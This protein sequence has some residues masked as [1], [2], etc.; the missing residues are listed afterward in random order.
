MSDGR[1]VIDAIFD[2][3]PTQ[4]SA[5]TLQRTLDGLNTNRYNERLRLMSAEMKAAY[6][7][8]RQALIPF[9]RELME[10][11]FKFFKMAQGMK[12]YSG[13]NAQFINDVRRLGQEHKTATENIMKNN[14]MMKA[15]FIQGVGQ[16]LARSGQSEKIAANFQRMGNPLYSVNNGLLRVTSS[17]ERVARQGNASV[18]ALK[19]LGPTA[20]M[21]QLND[22]TMMINQGLMRF[23]TVAIA[24]AA[25]SVMLYGKLHEAAMENDAYA[26]SFNT[27]MAT[28]KEAFK[29]M[30]DVFAAVMPYVYNF[31]TQ[32]AKMI[33]KFNEAHPVLSKMIAGFVLLLPALTLLLSPLAIGIGLINGMQAAFASV[34]M[35]IGPL[36]TGLGAMIGTVALV[37]AAIVAV[38]AALYLLW[39]K[40]DWFKQAVIGAWNAIKSATQ[41]A[42]NWI[43]NNII[44]PVLTAIQSFIQEKMQM[45]QQFWNENG[46]QIMQAAQNVWSVISKVI[47]TAMQV[48]GAIMQALWPVIKFLVIGTWEAIKNVINGAINVILGIIKFFSA[49]FTGDWKGVWEGAKQIIKG[50]LELIWGWVQLFG[51]GR[52]L[53]FFTGLGGKL[54]S[55][56]KSMWDKISSTFSN[57]LSKIWGWV[58]SKFEGIVSTIKSKMDAAKNKISSVWN[59]IKSFFSSVLSS[60][61]NGI[62][63][64]FQGMFSTISSK[65]SAAKSKISSIWNAIKSFFSNVLS[66]IWNTVKNK[67]QDIVSSVGDKMSAVY[68]KVKSIWN[69]V[70]SFFS[71]INLYN[72]GKDIIQGLINGIS[73]M[74]KSVWKK[75]QEIA[76]GVKNKIKKALRINSPSKIT[77]Q[78]GEWTGE[79]YE[80]GLDASQKDVMKAA[81]AL[82]A[83]ATPAL[84]DLRG[85]KASM[86]S[87]KTDPNP[88]NISGLVAAI[89]SMSDAISERSIEVNIPTIR[90]DLSINGRP[91][92]AAINKDMTKAQQRQAFT[93]KRRYK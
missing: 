61:W 83:A 92:A 67:F 73:S 16:M 6:R 7:Q 78:Y 28:I 80:I 57:A 41:A 35:I 89:Q 62:K 56:I 3:A 30:V 20:N 51:I 24:G 13:T 66:N 42:W 44:T 60:I 32:I 71:G 55:P 72:I 45:V 37:S 76:D 63:S 46:S 22:M 18:L 74:A 87:V 93:D 88:L 49:L 91:F 21:K 65:M 12:N 77:T 33:V 54:L 4:R 39:T 27:M 59:S 31:I 26:K 75:A 52:L 15:G 43:M 69:K 85:L 2:T 36:V 19:M 14:E 50:A 79:G 47:E 10:T 25:A 68:N 38:S 34:W 9:K 53:K 23:T 90:T 8:S 86:V 5:R 64:K 70:Q 17:L 40:T 81:D 58:K 11:E 29:P 84:P 82:S 1:V 48:I